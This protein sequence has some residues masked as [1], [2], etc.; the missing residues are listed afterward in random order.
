MSSLI[1]RNMAGRFVRNVVKELG[2]VS[3]FEPYK[4]RERERKERKG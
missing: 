3:N 1:E 2:K 4:V